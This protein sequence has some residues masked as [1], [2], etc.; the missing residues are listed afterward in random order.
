MEDYKLANQY[1]MCFKEAYP[2][3][4]EDMQK[5]HYYNRPLF[6]ADPY[7]TARREGERNVVLRIMTII[8][9]YEKGEIKE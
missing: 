4:L 6:A 2:K 7:E 3:I 5:A 9:M 8:D 1:V